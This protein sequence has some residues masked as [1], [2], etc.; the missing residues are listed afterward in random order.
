MPCLA[1][2]PEA[3]WKPERVAS[4]L[5]LSRKLLRKLDLELSITDGPFAAEEA[6]VSA[7]VRAANEAAS[8]PTP[9]A[10]KACGGTCSCSWFT[11]AWA[12]CSAARQRGWCWVTWLGWL[13]ELLLQLPP[14]LLQASPACH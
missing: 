6:P 11:I 13:D 3:A 4:D 8:A 9:A 7:P 1:Q 14:L 12:L 10:G 2:V 5:Q